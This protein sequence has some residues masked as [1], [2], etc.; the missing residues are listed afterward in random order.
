MLPK[1]T[2]NFITNH[3]NINYLLQNKSKKMQIQLQ[4]V[5]NYTQYIISQYKEK[6]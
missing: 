6:V 1:L 3:V 5:C 2:I 4:L